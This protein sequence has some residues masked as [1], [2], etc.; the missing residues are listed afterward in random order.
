MPRRGR[1]GAEH[2][3]ADGVRLA[4]PGA[5]GGAVDSVPLAQLV[6]AALGHVLE[7]KGAFGA[8]GPARGSAGPR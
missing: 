8:A 1:V 5:C 4:M 2:G 6:A 3:G 7:A